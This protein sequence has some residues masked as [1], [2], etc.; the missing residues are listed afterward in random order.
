MRFGA[1]PRI[2]LDSRP[3]NGFWRPE[4]GFWRPEFKQLNFRIQKLN[5]PNSEILSFVG[6]SLPEEQ[7]R[8]RPHPA[9]VVIG[10]PQFEDALN[11]DKS[12]A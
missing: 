12:A 6:R 4:S 9:F 2:S 11:S 3:K 1:N 8:K 10:P 7:P 5:F